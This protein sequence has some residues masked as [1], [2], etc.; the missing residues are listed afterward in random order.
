MTGIYIDID[1][2]QTKAMLNKMASQLTVGQFDRMMYFSLKDVGT[3][4]K[5][6]LRKETMRYY[7]VDKDFVDPAI[8]PPKIEGGGGNWRCDIPLIGPKGHVGGTFKAEGGHYGWH[9]PKYKIKARIVKGSVS[10]LPD[11]MPNQGGQPPWRNV[12]EERKAGKKGRKRRKMEVTK[13]ANKINELA[14][15]RTGSERMPIQS[16]SA[17][18]MPQMPMN[19]ARPNVEREVL[20]RLDKR[21]THYF[22]RLFG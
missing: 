11:A 7:E 6:V 3:G 10:T 13:S 12:L 17:L 8:R 9:P 2:G 19:R 15:T 22:S 4:M 18:A 16:I 14:M 20:T 1:A 21:T 5:P